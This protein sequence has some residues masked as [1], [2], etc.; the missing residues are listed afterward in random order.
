MKKLF[1]RKLLT[2]IGWKDFSLHSIKATIGT[3]HILLQSNTEIQINVKQRE[4]KH[5]VIEIRKVRGVEEFSQIAQ[6]SFF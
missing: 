2:K 6:I 3:L 4:K 1:G 5:N